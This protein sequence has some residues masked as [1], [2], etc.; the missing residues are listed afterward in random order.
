MALIGDKRTWQVR[1]DKANVTVSGKTTTVCAKGCDVTFSTYS[2]YFYGPS[3]NITALNK[4]LG[5]TL[6]RGY[7][8]FDCSK[9]VGLPS[10]VFTLGGRSFSI[11]PA[12]YVVNFSGTCYSSFLSSGG[13]FW[14]LGHIFIKSYYSVFDVQNKRIGLATSV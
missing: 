14:Q 1:L 13:D 10:V 2:P 8:I 7:Y 4:A 3:D 12:F 6:S 5:A 9:V 11:K